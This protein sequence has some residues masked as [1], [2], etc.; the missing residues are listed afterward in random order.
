MGEEAAKLAL[1]FFLFCTLHTK[2]MKIW[3]S[4]GF[5]VTPGP[6]PDS[7]TLIRETVRILR[8]RPR[9]QDVLHEMD[10]DHQ[11]IRVSRGRNGG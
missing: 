5:P 8:K 11:P 2:E 1:A 4:P 7:L 3:L 6:T 9:P 10:A